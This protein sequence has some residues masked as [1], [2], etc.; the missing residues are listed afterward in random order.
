MTPN[1]LKTDPASPAQRWAENGP[2]GTRGQRT[3]RSSRLGPPETLSSHSLAS[4]AVCTLRPSLGWRHCTRCGEVW[5]TGPGFVLKGN[6]S[7]GGRKKK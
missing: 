7:G 1:G 5:L 6:V 4:P 3:R 2:H